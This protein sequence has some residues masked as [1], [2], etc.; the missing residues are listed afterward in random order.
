MSL[1]SVIAG[2]V[3][4]TAALIGV[5]A[6]SSSSTSMHAPVAAFAADVTSAGVVLIDVRTPAEFSAGHIAGAVNIDLNGPDFAQRI[7]ALDK[8][9]RYAVYCQSGHR[10]GIALDAMAA[11]GFTQVEDLAG[12]VQAWVAAGRPLTAG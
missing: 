7:N 10:S 8:G 11:A 3:V 1:R 6:C 4:G 9:V 12:G 5:S 2:L